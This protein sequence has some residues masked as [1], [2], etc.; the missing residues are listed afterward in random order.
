MRSNKRREDSIEFGE[1]EIIEMLSERRRG[2]PLW[3]RNTQ[4]LSLLGLCDAY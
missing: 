2:A 3:S 4:R 1:V